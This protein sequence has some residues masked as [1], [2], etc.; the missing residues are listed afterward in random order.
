M[1]DQSEDNGF[2]CQP[3]GTT[4]AAV[5]AKVTDTQET[6]HL[7]FRKLTVSERASERRDGCVMQIMFAATII[8]QARPFARTLC[9]IKHTVPYL[10]YSS[11][12]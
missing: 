6:S 11:A 2:G 3:G 8:M 1:A 4:A 5:A 9:R 7:V 12:H 10:L